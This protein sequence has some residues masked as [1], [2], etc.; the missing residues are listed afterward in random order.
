MSVYLC[1]CLCIC[2]SVRFFGLINFKIG[3][4]LLLG[5]LNTKQNFFLPQTLPLPY[6]SPKGK[7]SRNINYSSTLWWIQLKLSDN[8]SYTH[9]QLLEKNLSRTFHLNWVILQPLINFI[10]FSF[11]KFVR[12]SPPKRLHGF[13]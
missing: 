1:I 7:F 12:L 3:R 10:K 2:V 9:A 8:L 6:P 5:P 13:S 4:Q 11:L